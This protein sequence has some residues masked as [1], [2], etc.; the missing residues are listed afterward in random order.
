MFLLNSI[1]KFERTVFN[2]PLRNAVKDWQQRADSI[3]FM[4]KVIFR[5]DIFNKITKTNKDFDDGR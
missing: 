5:G 1:G 2:F 4:K 3:T